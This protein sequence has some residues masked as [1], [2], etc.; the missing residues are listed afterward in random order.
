MP[1]TGTKVLLT[2]GLLP[3]GRSLY[4]DGPSCNLIIL[5]DIP[6]TQEKINRSVLHS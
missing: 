4:S 2:A 6:E 5:G 3:L 1:L